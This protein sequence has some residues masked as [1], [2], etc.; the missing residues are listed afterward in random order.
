M[1]NIEVEEYIY[2][3]MCMYM[4][5]YM[6]RVYDDTGTKNDVTGKKALGFKFHSI[7]E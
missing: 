7:Q 4:Y 1:K 3:C 2:I 5:M 6:A